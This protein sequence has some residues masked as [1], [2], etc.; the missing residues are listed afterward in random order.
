MWEFFTIVYLLVKEHPW[1]RRPTAARRDQRGPLAVAPPALAGFALVGGGFICAAAVAGIALCESGGQIGTGTVRAGTRGVKRTLQ[2]A[3]HSK[4][5][6]F[7]VL[8]IA[9]RHA[10]EEHGRE[11]TPDLREK[12][13][14][15][16]VDEPAEAHV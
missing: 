4:P 1:V 9:M 13:R 8:A 6:N 16:L 5:P 3:V 10:V 14:G 11:H 2:A 15:I 7:K 12:L